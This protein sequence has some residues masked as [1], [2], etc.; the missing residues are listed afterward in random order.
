MKIK[1]GNMVYDS[2]EQMIQI[3]LSEE[4]KELISNMGNQTKFC[5][6]PEH[7]DVDDVKKFMNTDGI[8]YIDIISYFNRLDH[9]LKKLALS[10][11]SVEYAQHIREPFNYV[12]D[13][14]L[15]LKEKYNIDSKYKTKEEYFE[16]L[17]D[18]E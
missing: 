13:A 10:D 1:I 15:S 3:E 6:F 8:K 12:I 11:S 9:A 4:E 14:I 18:K 16:F 7:I 5:S 17:F 2:N